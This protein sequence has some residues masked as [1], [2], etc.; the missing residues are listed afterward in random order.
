ME[1]RIIDRVMELIFRLRTTAQK[2]ERDCGIPPGQLSVAKRDGRELSMSQVRKIELRYDWLNKEW[3]ESGIGN[4][5]VEGKCMPTGLESLARLSSAKIETKPK[6]DSAETTVSSHTT[7]QET[8]SESSSVIK[9]LTETNQ[10][11]VT[12]INAL[13]N[14]NARLTEALAIAMQSVASANSGHKQ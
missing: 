5:T 13:T 3:L 9:S 7:R 6:H 14:S 4:M 10:M 12:T 8:S 11:L 2:F 1:Q